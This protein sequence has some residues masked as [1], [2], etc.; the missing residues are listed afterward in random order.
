M[1]RVRLFRLKSS[2]GNILSV[3]RIPDNDVRGL[4][5]RRADGVAH[6]QRCGEH[7]LF[8]SAHSRPAASLNCLGRPFFG[9]S[10]RQDGSLRRELHRR[11]GYAALLFQFLHPTGRTR[12]NG[13]LPVH[14]VPRSR[15]EYRGFCNLGS[16]RIR[17]Y[18]LR[19][20]QGR[21]VPAR[22]RRMASDTA[23]DSFDRRI[24]RAR[25][26]DVQQKEA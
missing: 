11:H 5:D 1:L 12:D 21:L 10:A 26:A 24:D 17:S 16:A 19:L 15:N 8:C 3:C 18:R 6:G 25:A 13:I 14:A 9:I 23:L 4:C 2:P 7:I 20:L 22:D